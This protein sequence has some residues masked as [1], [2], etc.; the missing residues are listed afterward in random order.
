MNLL[1]FEKIAEISIKKI[2]NPDESPLRLNP[3]LL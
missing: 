1:A 2:K 3:R